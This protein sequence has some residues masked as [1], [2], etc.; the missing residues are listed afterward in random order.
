MVFGF[1]HNVRSQLTDEVS[2]FPVGPIFTGQIKKNQK[3]TVL[4]YMY[5]VSGLWAE[6]KIRSSNT[7]KSRAVSLGKGCE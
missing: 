7:W 1:L 2:E 3:N 5:V 4:P 6:L